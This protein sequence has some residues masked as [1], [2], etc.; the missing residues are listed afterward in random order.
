MRHLVSIVRLSGLLALS[1]LLAVRPAMAQDI[2][3]IETPVF[4]ER[5]TSGE[6]PPVAERLP[7][8]PSVAEMETMGRH[9]G[10]MRL[11]MGRAKDIRLLVVYGYARLAKYRP[12][13]SIQADILK[14]IVLGRHCQ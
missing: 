2:P 7:T 13:L 14:D 11:L 12:D 1:I 10:Q 3:L 4:V 5:V 6:L 8:E 9:G